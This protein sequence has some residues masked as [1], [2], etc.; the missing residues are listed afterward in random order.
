LSWWQE[1]PRGAE[2]FQRPTAIR[3]VKLCRIHFAK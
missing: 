1:T 3:K 2:F